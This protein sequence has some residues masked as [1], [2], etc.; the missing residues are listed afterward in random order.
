MTGDIYRTHACDTLFNLVS[1][2]TQ[3]GIHLV[4]VP[5]EGIHTPHLSDRVIGLDNTHYVFTAARELNE[6]IEFKP[7]GLI[8]SRAQKVL[9]ESHSMLV[10]IQ[11]IGL[12]AAV[13]EGLFGDTSRSIEDGRGKEGVAL[14][15]AEYYNPISESIMEGKS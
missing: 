14:K 10:H 13:Q 9:S 8:Q 4:G 3:Q 6:E 2:A 5:T 7:G 12:F 1:I 11:K 15:A